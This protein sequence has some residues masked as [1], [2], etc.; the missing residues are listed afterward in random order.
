MKK[1]LLSIL[2]CLCMVMTLL[3]TVAFADT[4]EEA[5]ESAD[6]TT[7]PDTA[8]ELLNQYK[9]GEA[10]SAWNN[11]TN[12][13][14][15]NGINFATGAATALKLP[16][17]TTIVLAEGTTNTVIS[18]YGDANR[19]Y[20]V[21]ASS[22]LTIKGK[23]TLIAKGGAFKKGSYGIMSLTLLTGDADVI[24]MG[25]GYGVYSTDVTINSG[26]LTATG[27]SNTEDGGY[28]LYTN[29]FTANGGVVILKG[30][31]T[32]M[33]TLGF[34]ATGAT[35]KGSA[36]YNATELTAAHFDPALIYIGTEDTTT[37]AKTA[38][39]T[40]GPIF[41]ARGDSKLVS[42][43]PA[44]PTWGDNAGKDNYTFVDWYTEIDGRGT[45][46]T[47]D[48]VDGTTY[49]AKWTKNGNTVR[50]EALDLSAKV[51][52]P[53][54]QGW[55]WDSTTQTLALNNATINT[56]ETISDIEEFRE[57]T[58]KLPDGATIELSANTE[59]TVI[60][61]FDGTYGSSSSS[62]VLSGYGALTIEGAGTLSAMGGVPGRGEGGFGI[63]AGALV[64]QG[65]ST[66]FAANS[67]T[68]TDSCANRA[69][70]CESLVITEGADVTAISADCTSS[71]CGIEVGG[72]MTVS[73]NAT[74]CATGGASS[75]VASFGLSAKGTLSIDHAEVIAESGNGAQMSVGTAAEKIELN[76]GS[77]HATGDEA[78]MMSIGIYCA[79]KDDATLTG[80]DVAVFATGNYTAVASTASITL[81]LAG[82]ADYNAAS[83][84]KK[85]YTVYE[86]DSEFV[87]YQ[88]RMGENLA[89]AVAKTARFGNFIDFDA[90]S[91]ESIDYVKIGDNNMTLPTN[92]TW[93]DNAAK[94]N[95]TFG[96]W[97][98]GID[99]TGDAI[100]LAAAKA[101][102]AS[103][104]LY[105]KWTNAAGNTV[106]TEVLDL[107]AETIPN[108]AIQS[109]QGWTWDSKSKTLT[110]S[111]ATINTEDV[112]GR[113]AIAL[114]LSDNTTIVLADGTENTAI[115]TKI[116]NSENNVGN[117]Y[118]V[119]SATDISIQGSGTLTAIGGTARYSNGIYTYSGNLTIKDST[120]YAIAKSNAAAGDSRGICAKNI[121]IEGSANVTA[122][123]TIGNSNGITC[124]GNLAI[125]GG[126]I[127]AAGEDTAI[128][129][130][131]TVTADGATVKGGADFN[132]TELTAAHFESSN[133]YMGETG[134]DTMAK[135]A[136]ITFGPS[137]S[138]TTQPVSPTAMTVGSV[139]GNLSVTASATDD[140]AISY[141]W[142]KNTTNSTT[143]G[144]AIPGATSASY[145]IPATLTKGSYYYYC[146]LKADGCEDV[147]TR[148]AAVTVNALKGNISG[149]VT[150][151]DSNVSDAAVMLMQGTDKIAATTSAETTG[152]Y[153]FSAVEY[154]VYSVVVTKTIDGKDKT[155]TVSL[156]LSSENA[157]VNVDI[158][159]VSG[160]QNTLV[161]TSGSTTPVT[162]SN[163]NDLF[164]AASATENDKGITAADKTAVADGGTVEIK[165]TAEAKTLGNVTEDANKIRALSADSDANYLFVDL[166]VTK[167]VNRET[168]VTLKETNDLIEVSMEIPAAYQ[169]SGLRIFRIHEGVAEELKKSANSFGEYFTLSSDCTVATLHIKRFSTFALSNAVTPT[170][171][172][173][174][175]GGSS[176]YTI[177]AGAAKNGTIKVSHANAAS[178]AKVTV[179]VTPDKGYALETLKAAKANGDEV[180][181]TKNSNGTYSFTMPSAKVTLTATFMEDNTMLNFFTDVSASAYYYNA[182][183]W[184]AENGIT[185]GTTAT[186]F[187][188]NGICTRAQAVTF[189]WRAMGSPEPTG[190]A[191]SFTDVS[192]SAYYYKAVLWA[193]EKGIT[194]GT[195]ATTFSPDMT[196]SRAHVV[197]FLWRAA[198]KTDMTA[199][200]SFA[201]VSDAAYYAHAVAWAAENEITSGT[202]ATTF[203]PDN[204]CTRAQIVTFIYRYLSK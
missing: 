116:G 55:N 179:T 10:D 82:S 184:A 25:A 195:S 203:S 166:T 27:D 74:V 93:G 6:F 189:L 176:T 181:L 47:G 88:V 188:P 146:T 120:I 49:Y 187:S 38:R 164:D 138:V 109:A 202:T 141:Q 65:D 148:V 199:A 34:T 143:G 136:K 178:G 177:S 185:S 142:Y 54:D 86:A 151:G 197:T 154:G 112:I 126:T 14:T 4:P 16:D 139:S 130:A 64:I 175:S 173:G 107:S 133:I 131:G 5:T 144:T 117:S 39:V 198:G 57:I 41:D 128:Y 122:T 67:A 13:L 168:P 99:G 90:R 163:L 35:I 167:T 157:T 127:K 129:F 84:L 19:T 22:K 96:G 191:C 97:Y 193:T 12:T 30:A 118:G 149:V 113:D 28:G 32:A 200:Q 111:N 73:N 190:T 52:N 61:T 152:A 172:T 75:N 24:A 100:D 87:P 11:S 33:R 8:L 29:S 89:D 135:T 23:G 83:T 36:E 137:I 145:T 95:Y 171:S 134:T 45:L 51:T 20:G 50:T 37:K 69:I 62:E 80:T 78:T 204:G 77:L 59:N 42:A 161:E 153:S 180:A 81:T 1:R 56:A 46:L 48:P 71:N 91:G 2:L 17:D 125:S 106:R 102:T 140:R 31:N 110:L 60:S 182:V 194:V 114:N 183:L 155:I 76:S 156:V 119:Y 159:N 40:F 170:Q 169:T 3:P 108:T 44:D 174:G 94:D 186:T 7:D 15:L 132:A 192:A 162:A 92:P 43:K 123:A 53:G 101:L 160:N 115:N 58:V 85:A 21:Y 68:R 150:K 105:A 26:Y 18:N 196:V 70:S 79:N 124:Y 165:L 9:T 103:T 121:M 66:V 201:D 147:T 98:T 72:N 63:V 104:T 158:P